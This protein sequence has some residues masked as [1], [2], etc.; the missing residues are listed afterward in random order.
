MQILIQISDL[1][2]IYHLNSL[3]NRLNQNNLMILNLNNFL[4]IKRDDLLILIKDTIKNLW[5]NMDQDIDLRFKK[6]RK[7]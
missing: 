6:H 4:I 3:Q 2:M 7:D 5:I 1:N